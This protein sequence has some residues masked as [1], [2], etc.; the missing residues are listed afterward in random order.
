MR[1]FKWTLPLTL[2][3]ICLLVSG[4]DSD[5]QED[6]WTIP[7]LETHGFPDFV[8]W[9]ECG[10]ME[11]NVGIQ[12]NV[13]EFTI[14][15][16]DVN[17]MFESRLRAARLFSNIENSL[18]DN[19]SFTLYILEISRGDNK[20]EGLSYHFQVRYQRILDLGYGEYSYA[21]I[22]SD[23]GLGILGIDG[24]SSLL[25]HISEYVDKFILKYL[26]VN[27]QACDNLND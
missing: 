24:K 23:G 19:I 4:S 18:N 2:F 17:N 14:K 26:Q 22:W 11:V 27:E 12:N 10:K 3:S 15:D 20:A 1:R 6:E 7:T 25:Q 8:L 21:T 9:N 5:D 13:D 16:K